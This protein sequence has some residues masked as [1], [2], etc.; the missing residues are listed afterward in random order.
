MIMKCMEWIFTTHI[1]TRLLFDVC[2]FITSFST[3]IL[4]EI[5]LHADYDVCLYIEY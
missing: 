1:E 2:L 5:I 4:F 3:L